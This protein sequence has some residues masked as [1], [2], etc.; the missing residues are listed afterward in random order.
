MFSDGNKVDFHL[1]H[2]L[3][4]IIIVFS[5][6]EDAGLSKTTPFVRFSSIYSAFKTCFK[7]AFHC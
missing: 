2:L 6:V 3:L 1:K 5:P 4:Y 7:L